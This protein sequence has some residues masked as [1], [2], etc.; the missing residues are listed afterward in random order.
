MTEFEYSGHEYQIGPMDVFTQFD[1]AAK[2]SPLIVPL[3]MMARNDGITAQVM[4]S[5]SDDARSRIMSM[6]MENFEQMAQ[7]VA[8][9]PAEDRHFIL[10]E[11]FKV[12]SRRQ[13]G[14]VGWQPVW[15]ANGDKLQYADL[16]S[17]PA[18]M[19]LCGRVIGDKLSSFF[20]EPRSE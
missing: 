8:K 7:L 5:E 19:T 3:A 11:C 14:T 10:R 9:M 18:A 12:L 4:A 15:N 13:K 16:D 17:L 20:P 1:L 2:L 6:L